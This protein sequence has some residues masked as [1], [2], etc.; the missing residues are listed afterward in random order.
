MLGKSCCCRNCDICSDDFNRTDDTN[1]DT[2][3]SCSWT[4]SSGSWDITSNQLRCT[5]AGIAIAFTAHPDS[6]STMS[7]QADF[8]HDTST[9]T[10]DILVA[11]DDSTHYYYARFKVAGA[12]GS[13]DIRWK[14]GASDTSLTLLTGVTMN[15]STTYT[16]RVCVLE[17]GIIAVF[18]NSTLRVAS[19]PVALSGTYSGL[20]ASGS[21]T[22]TFDN[23][24]VSRA[25][26]S[27]SA[28]ECGR[29]AACSSSICNSGTA[30]AAVQL[31]ISGITNGACTDC[32]VLNGSFVLQYSPDSDFGT[33]CVYILDVRGMSSCSL[34]S[35]L[36]FYISGSF[37]TAGGY[38]YGTSPLPITILF[39]SSPAGGTPLDCCAQLSTPAMTTIYNASDCTTSGATCTVTCLE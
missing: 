11:V 34:M 31:D 10:C 22:A 2:G 35:Y 19:D 8:K 1:I 28:T 13:I 29:C 14:D 37:Q 26:N 36:I 3:S 7:V 20:G 32:A 38:H 9:S 30:P 5:S 23:F 33:L 39:S 27:A 21:G 6:V 18:L 24:T 16:G 4:E 12:S 25:Y 17:Q 15:T